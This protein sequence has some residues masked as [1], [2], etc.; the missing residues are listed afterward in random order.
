MLVLHPLKTKKKTTT[1]LRRRLLVSAAN[2]PVAREELEKK[3][4]ADK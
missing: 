3:R 4:Y 1:T 2:L